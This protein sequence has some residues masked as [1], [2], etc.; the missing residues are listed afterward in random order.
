MSS[1][2]H[3]VKHQKVNLIFGKKQNKSQINKNYSYLWLYKP[4]MDIYE[5]GNDNLRIRLT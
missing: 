4:G 2:F 3:Y 1:V 5:L